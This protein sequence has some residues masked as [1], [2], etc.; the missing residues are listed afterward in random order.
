MMY[1][2]GLQ[3]PSRDHWTVLQQVSNNRSVLK[4]QVD[5]PVRKQLRRELFIHLSVSLSN[6]WATTT[7]RI[8]GAVPQVLLSH[9]AQHGFLVSPCAANGD[10]APSNSTTVLLPLGTEH[11]H[12]KT[13]LQQRRLNRD[14]MFMGVCLEAKRRLKDWRSEVARPLYGL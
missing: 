1:V 10:R 4:S 3:S 7:S 11:I 13:H 9:T 6:T 5:P 12:A 2:T 14:E 8:K